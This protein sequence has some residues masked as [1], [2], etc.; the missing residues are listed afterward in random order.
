QMTRKSHDNDGV[1][2]AV[3]GDVVGDGQSVRRRRVLDPR[4]VHRHSLARAV[5]PTGEGNDLVTAGDLTFRGDHGR[6]PPTRRTAAGGLAPSTSGVERP[7]HGPTPRDTCPC[8][9]P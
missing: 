9:T 2:V 7:G 5:V 3:A 6:A 4:E 8:Q 1:L